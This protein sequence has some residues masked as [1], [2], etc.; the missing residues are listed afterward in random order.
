M[1][2]ELLPQAILMHLRD[3]AQADV[4]EALRLLPA[5][6]RAARRSSVERRRSVAG[7]SLDDSLDDILQATAGARQRRVAR[8]R[9][10]HV[11][12]F[13]GQSAP[14]R[15]RHLVA[16]A[17]QLHEHGVRG[18]LIHVQPCPIFGQAEDC[19]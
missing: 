14:P 5:V 18:R 10:A 3:G 19:A 17:A 4:A 12:D 1:R 16:H 2:L 9:V 8:D 15:H 6:L 11:V 13:V 7:P